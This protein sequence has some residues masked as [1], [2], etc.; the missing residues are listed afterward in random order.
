MFLET[1]KS[2]NP[3]LIDASLYLRKKNLIL[4]DTYLL[5]LDTIIENTQNLV[6]EAQN[7]RIELFYMTKQFGRNPLIAKKISQSGI[8]DAVAVDYKEALLLKSHNL[9]IGNI[10]HLVQV[11][12]SLLEEFIVYGVKFITVYSIEQLQKIDAVCQK[13]NKQ[14]KVLIKVIEYKD[15]IY[16]GQKGG[17]TLDE[18]AK[19][20]A[21]HQSLH[22]IIAGITAFPCFLYNGES[23]LEPTE[24]INTLSLAKLILNDIGFYNLEVNMPSATSCNTIPMIKFLGGTQGEPGHALTGTT[25]LH[26]KKSLV[27]KP[28]LVYLTE[29]SHNFDHK[30]FI[31]GGGYYSRGH[32]KNV[33]IY[34]GDRWIDDDQIEPFDNENIDYY[35]ALSKSHPIG[36]SVVA[37]FRTQI[38]VTR[39][40]VAVVSGIQNG[41]VKLEGIFDSLGQQK[42]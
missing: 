31:F 6:Q 20:K 29:I 2:R 12:L 14:Q 10:G 17:F 34:Q 11:P 8:A 39:S 32:F 25:P 5:D 22:V 21:Y 13:Y 24:N 36:N 18:L 37:S 38:F 27:E 15:I 23:K 3:A 28:A 42:G 19:L 26:A 35:L 30:S 16:V 1:V 33:S 40:D 7:N 41:E 4:P 9:S